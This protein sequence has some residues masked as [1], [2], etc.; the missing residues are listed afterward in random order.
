MAVTGDKLLAG[1]GGGGL[2]EWDLRGGCALRRVAG[3]RAGCGQWVRCVAAGG[4]VMVTGSAY[5]VGDCEVRV[6]SLDSLACQR[7][8]PM[9]PSPD[10]ALPPCPPAQ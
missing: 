3:V 6:W 5:G 1:Y 10:A 9:V 2:V 7:S 8:M 4:G